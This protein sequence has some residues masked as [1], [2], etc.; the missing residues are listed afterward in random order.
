MARI[1]NLSI[2]FKNND[3][4]PKYW[5]IN[6][7]I[8]QRK[9]IITKR[10][11]YYNEAPFIVE[12]IYKGKRYLINMSSTCS[13]IEGIYSNKRKLSDTTLQVVCPEF[14]QDL[15]YNYCKLLLE[16]QEV[17]CVHC[18]EIISDLSTATT[19]IK[20]DYYCEDCHSNLTQCENCGTWCRAYDMNEDMTLCYRCEII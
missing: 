2:D 13:I 1:R 19:D 11:L 5:R 20:G 3:N 8:A 18:K 9:F 16:L 4:I 17:R 10:K 14:I 7:S 6:F 15:L 12:V